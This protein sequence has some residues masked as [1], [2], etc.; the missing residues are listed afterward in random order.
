MAA[1][2]GFMKDALIIGGGIAGTTLSYRLHASGW[3]IDL[4][5]SPMPHSASRVASGLYNPLVLKRRRI[6]W[7]APE[8]ME[9]LPDFYSSMEQYL[10]ASFVNRVPVWE[11]L[12]DAGAENDWIGLTDQPKFESLLGSIIKN[13][14]S[15]IRAKSIGEVTGSGWVD[16]PAML[17][18][19]AKYLQTE[20]KY[21]QTKLS[22]DELV[23]QDNKWWYR[24]VPY[25]KVIWT[26]G[27]QD[28]HPH[29]PLLKFSPTKGEVL[30]VKSPELQLDHILHG[31]VFIM[32]LG[33]DLYKVGATYS[34]KDLDTIPTSEGES[35]LIA[36]WKKLVDANFEIVEHVA[37]VRPNVQ[38]RKPILG[39][40]ESHPESYIFNGFGSRGILMAPWLTQIMHAFLN[41]ENTLPHEVNVTRF[42]K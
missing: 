19:W 34:W 35:K 18:A 7:K 26:I 29:F 3:D 36:E 39:K 17:E 9:A 11:V 30:I 28:E 8:M 24:E 16:V 40:S 27:F 31:G 12:P 20:S 25:R 33:D 13:S 2:F 15:K 14:N 5:D 1:F 37:G 6:V 41:G 23:Y 21:I 42:Q 22:P 32:P 10:Q 4:V 38:D